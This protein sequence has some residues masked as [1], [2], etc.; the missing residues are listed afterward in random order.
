MTVQTIYVAKFVYGNGRS[1]YGK[2]TGGRGGTHS[3][4]PAD[5]GQL[6]SRGLDFFEAGGGSMTQISFE[7]P[8]AIGKPSGLAPYR[9]VKLTE[10]EQEEF[11]NAFLAG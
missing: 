11:W 3:H 10:Q 2:T 1:D 6:V 4:S 9:L 7:L 8:Y 5:I